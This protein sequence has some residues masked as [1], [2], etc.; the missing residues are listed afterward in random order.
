M[1][2]KLNRRDFLLLLFVLAPIVFVLPTNPYKLSQWTMK[3]ERAD[4]FRQR[5]VG[6]DWHT[7]LQDRMGTN[8]SDWKRKLHQNLMQ[9]YHWGRSMIQTFDSC[10]MSLESKFICSLTFLYGFLM[11]LHASRRL[12]LPLLLI[13]QALLHTNTNPISFRKANTEAPL[14]SSPVPKPERHH[15]FQNLLYIYV[16]R[17]RNLLEPCT[18]KCIL[19]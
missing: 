17:N 5:D 3:Y 18:V 1:Q 11:P 7:Y 15:M 2:I 13:T 19:M 10:L 14:S 4:F 16:Q 6:F 9:E 12:T 8:D